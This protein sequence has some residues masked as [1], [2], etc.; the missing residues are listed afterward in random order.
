[1][2]LEKDKVYKIRHKFAYTQ[3]KEMAK[4]GYKYISVLNKL[5]KKT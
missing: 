2:I 4:M 3:I 1:M 5:V